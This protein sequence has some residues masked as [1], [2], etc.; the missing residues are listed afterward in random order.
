MTKQDNTNEEPVVEE[1]VLEL[2]NEQQEEA[3]FAEFAAQADGQESE[4]PESIDVNVVEDESELAEVADEPDAETV[5]EEPQVDTP[6]ATPDAETPDIW[7]GANEKQ[8][9]E[10]DK[11]QAQI[12]RMGH[13]DRSNRGRVSALQ[14]KVNNLSRKVVEN[15]GKKPRANAAGNP[16]EFGLDPE[17]L[18]ELRK[19]FPEVVQIMAATNKRYTTSIN[20]LQDK[21]D[22]QISALQDQI[23]PVL[24]DRNVS[25]LATEAE[26]LVAEHSDWEAIQAGTDFWEWRAEQPEAVQAIGNEPTA[27]ATSTLLKLYKIDRQL[28]TAPAVGAN[29]SAAESAAASR[30]KKQLDDMTALPAR[31]AGRNKGTPVTEGDDWD[32]FAA[33]ADKGIS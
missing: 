31:G 18:K 33:A 2:T 5:A 3:D 12:E 19:D 23:T 28:I 9:A 15:P 16:A 24:D 13:S 27:Q 6:E 32:E 11:L 25:A 26:L 20:S 29:D 10:R 8:L 30:K 21:F 1:E 22:G 4:S 14:T 17:K 7:D